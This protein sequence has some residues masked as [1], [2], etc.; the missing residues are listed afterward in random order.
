MTSPTPPTDPIDDEEFTTQLNQLID[1]ARNSDIQLIGAWNAR[2]PHPD[3]PDYTIEITEQTK[4]SPAWMQN[5]NRDPPD[6]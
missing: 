3:E 1:R 6:E 4:R 5:Q 2:S